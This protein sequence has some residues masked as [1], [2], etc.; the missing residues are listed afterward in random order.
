MAK[1]IF[2][3]KKQKQTRHKYRQ[4]KQ[5]EALQY[6][7]YDPSSPSNPKKE[8]AY[9]ALKIRKC[10]FFNFIIN[11]MYIL[12]NQRERKISRERM[13]LWSEKTKVTIDQISDGKWLPKLQK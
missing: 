9:L 6:E 13:F 4:N 12:D 10:E 2:Q 5:K 7:K 8:N 1:A 3:N 11:N